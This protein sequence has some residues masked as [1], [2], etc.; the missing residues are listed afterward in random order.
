MHTDMYEEHMCSLVEFNIYKTENTSG[1][2]AFVFL[3]C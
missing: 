3:S 2:C 1:D